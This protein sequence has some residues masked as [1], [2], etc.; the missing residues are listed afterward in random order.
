MSRPRT[1]AVLAAAAVVLGALAPL[2]GNAARG[3]ATVGVAELT[4]ELAAGEPLVD[5][6]TLGEWIR[7]RRPLR[8][9]DVRPDSG[10]F[11]RFSVPTAAH[12]PFRTLPDRVLSERTP[13][14]RTPLDR[15][16]LDRTPEGALPDSVTLVLYD[17]EGSGDAARSWLLLRRLG[18]P[19]VRILRRGVIGWIDGIVRPVLPAGTPAERE[20]YERVAA[21]SRYFGGLPRVGEPPDGAPAGT[22]D[23]SPADPPADAD[24]AVQL[25][26]RRGCY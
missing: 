7:E 21:V 23:A 15:T 25:L 11:I 10:A 14:D 13:L 24:R 8:V 6:V 3:P 9:W 22:G 1:G 26:S 4:A 12:V 19:D 5:A 2:A 17:A 16:P 18:Y 20:R